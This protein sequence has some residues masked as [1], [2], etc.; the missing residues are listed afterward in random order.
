MRF[1][2][3]RLASISSS[4]A[5]CSSV[6]RAIDCS[7]SYLLHGPEKPS[8]SSGLSFRSCFRFFIGRGDSKTVLP[9][10]SYADCKSPTNDWPSLSS[11]F[12]DGS[13]ANPY[14]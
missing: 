2:R 7:S 11:L 6:G 9:F 5:F 8:I 3:C 13:K 12:T 10:V 4:S 1:L 14:V